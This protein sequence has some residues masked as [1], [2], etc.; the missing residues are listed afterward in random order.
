MSR[1]RQFN[2][3]TFLRG[4]GVAVAL[5][6]LDAMLPSLSRAATASVAAQAQS[7]VRMA[8]LYVPNGV[9]IQNWTPATT[10]STYTL[11]RI[12]EPLAAHKSDFNIL[13]GLAQHNG[14]ALGDAEG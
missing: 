5:P 4:A 14:F 12:L 10:G 3:R 6:F 7:P 1:P 11:P 2:R 9:T 13:T 8:F